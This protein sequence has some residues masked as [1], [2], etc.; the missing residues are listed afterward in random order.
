M[1]KIL[2]TLKKIKPFWSEEKLFMVWNCKSTKEIQMLDCMIIWETLLWQTKIKKANYKLAK[3]IIT[4]RKYY[5]YVVK[6]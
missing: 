4:K 3:I 2:K 5:R 6:I 1:I